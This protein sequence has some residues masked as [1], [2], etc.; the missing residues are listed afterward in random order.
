MKKLIE[1]PLAHLD[2]FIRLEISE[3]SFA[4]RQHKNGLISPVSEDYETAMEA[5]YRLERD[6]IEV[7]NILSRIEA[8]QAEILRW[9]EQMVYSLD[10]QFIKIPG[11][12]LP[13]EFD[14]VAVKEFLLVPYVGACIHVPPPPKNQ[15]IFVE[16]REPF[17]VDSLF[18]PVWVVGRILVKDTRKTLPVS[19]GEI[20]I[21][22]GY[23][24]ENGNVEPYRE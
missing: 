12:A 16:L 18:E 19:D 22:A 11:Y 4:I 6:G 7:E 2:P 17:A 15:M 10:G 1:D 13:I 24:I 5:K 3:I 14:G 8:I 20:P 23:L 21:R 9:G